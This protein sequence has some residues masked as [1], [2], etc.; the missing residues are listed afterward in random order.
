[1]QRFR[2]WLAESPT[3]NNVAANSTAGGGI[4]GIGPDISFAR[5]DA[6]PRGDDNANI[7]RD[8][9]KRGHIRAAKLAKLGL[10]LADIRAQMYTQPDPYIGKE[11]L[12]AEPRYA[13]DT[14]LAPNPKYSFDQKAPPVRAGS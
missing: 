1:M 6:T 13:F 14:V 9:T 3:P 5:N 10:Y 2:I 11:N 12:R 4:D 8:N 7:E